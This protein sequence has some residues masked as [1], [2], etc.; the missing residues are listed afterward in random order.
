MRNFG[1]A[2]IRASLGFLV[3][4]FSGTAIGA[5]TFGLLA[6]LSPETGR[7]FGGIGTIENPVQF[8]AL[9]GTFAGGFYGAIIGAANGLANLGAPGGTTIGVLIGTIIAAYV[10]LQANYPIGD[11]VFWVIFG[12]AVLGFITGVLLRLISERF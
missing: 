2:I 8:S 11:L 9:I 6:A 4:A 10:F 1:K 12:G 7:S 5:L 3:G